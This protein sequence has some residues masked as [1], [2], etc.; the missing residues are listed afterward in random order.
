VGARHLLK[1]YL[2]LFGF[3][4]FIAIQS[5]AVELSGNAETI[6]ERGVIELQGRELSLHGVQIIPQNATCKDSNGQWSCGKSAWE[7]LKTKLDSGPIH[8]TLISD[9]QNTE[10]NPEQANC[11][12]K[13]GNLSIWLV[14]QGW[15]L[16]SKEPEELLSSQENLARENNEGI[17]RDG[18][19]PT[20]LWRTSF[21][22]KSKHCNVCSVRRQSFLRKTPK[23]KTP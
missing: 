21:K 15:A 18:F 7:A 1:F 11:L 6:P 17:W 8:C 4:L 20:D 19:I 22:K 5:A 23:Q 9:L 3:F 10:R 16:T 2:P 13:K 12:L 14:S